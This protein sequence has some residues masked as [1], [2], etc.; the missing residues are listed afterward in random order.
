MNRI[1]STS[2]LETNLNKIKS[3]T[4]I[5]LIFSCLIQLII[6]EN[7]KNVFSILFLFLSNLIILRYCL[8]QNNIINYPVSIFAIIFFNF[9]A[10]GGAL[11]FK[12]IL[13]E[14]LT[15]NL[16]QPNKTFLIL[17][18]FNIFVLLSHFFY[19][20]IKTLEKLKVKIFKILNFININEQNKNGVKKFFIYLGICSVLFAS[21]SFTFFGNFIYAQNL[22]SPNFLGDLI[23][24]I[25]IFYISGFIILFS[26]N[27]YNFDFSRKDYFLVF[28]S[29]ALIFYLSLGLNSRSAFFDLAF[30][31]L[32]IYVFHYFLGFFEIKVLRINKIF[33]I[34]ILLMIS[35]NLIDRFSQT[36]IE[37]RELRDKTNPIQ[38][39]KNHFSSFLDEKVTREYAYSSSENIFN[40]NYYK[41]KLLNRINII[42]A[43]DNVL[44]AKKFLNTQQINNLISY[45]KNQTISILPNP[46]IKVFNNSFDK[47]K[48]LNF[49]MTS[50]I[51]IEVDRSFGGSKS[52]GLIYPIVYIYQDLLITI[53][54]FLILIC[55]FLFLDAFYN[56]NEKKFSILLFLFF[57][58]T[59]GGIVNSISQGSI[60]DLIALLVRDIPQSLLILFILYKLFLLVF[61]KI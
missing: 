21:I 56:K 37:S 53:V 55:C 51:F 32:L 58:S 1:N 29:G 17:L 4:F 60:S 10:N 61:K 48:Y 35:T 7:Y 39:I 22:D 24:G 14:D 26:N 5:F 11:F 6:L 36:Y 3:L 23:N 33:F 50:K 28:T 20:K 40:E 19:K 43:T 52:N 30:V 46:I 8:N 54:T 15:L 45:E 27:F 49:S 42:K 18:L 57:Y 31:G 2:F 44:Y 34:F 16:Y 25:N 41:V 9:Y 12:S 38:N 47:G 13:L 59:G